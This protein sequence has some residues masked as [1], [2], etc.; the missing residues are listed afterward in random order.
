M[1]SRLTGLL[2]ALALAGFGGSGL[3]AQT[4]TVTG[5]VRD[6]VNLQP[7]AGAQLT[8]EGTGVGGLVNNVGRFLLLNVPA[9]EQTV[10]A[11]LIG[12]G[13]VTQSVTVAAGGTATL[14]FTLREQALS[15]E[16]VI[17]TGT[18]GTARRREIGN[19]ISQVSAADIEV[20]A[21]TDIGD[22]LQGRATG[23][24][25]NDFGG[26]V[27]AGSQIRLRGNS[28]MSAGN[29]P[30][31]YIDGVRMESNPV[32]VDGE[33]GASPSALDM[34]NPNDIER[35]EIVKGPAATTLY[36]TEASGG[37]IQVFTKRGNAGAPAW[38]LD[39][40]QGL[41]QMGHQGGSLNGEDINPTG[42]YLNDCTVRREYDNTAMQFVTIPL[43][44]PGAEV[45]CPSSGSWFQAGHMQ[46]YNLSVRGGGETATY[47]VS[48]RFDD[49]EGVVNPQEAVSYGV[50]ANIS[51]QPFDGMD[52]S[53]NNSF[54]RRN[55]TWIPDGNNASGFLL[56]VMRGS[57]DYTS[58]NDA[59]V[60]ENDIFSTI[61]QYQTSASVGW[62]PNVNWSHRLNVGL[63]Y[64]VMDYLDWK[65]WDYFTAQTGFRRLDSDQDRNVTFDYTGSFSYNP[66]EAVSSR[67]SFGGQLY[68]EQNYNIFGQDDS[69]AGPGEPEVG[70]GTNRNA[71]ET[72][73][74]V[75][76]G[77]FFLQE[78]IGFQDKL[79]LTGG[80]RWDGFSTFGEGFGLAAYPKLSASYLLSDESF[81]PTGV[82]ETLKLRAAWG[83][84]GKAPGVFEAE[85]LWAATSADEQEAAIVLDNFGNPDLGPERSVE[86]ELG[87]DA[88]A[89]DSRV[90]L[91]FTWYDQTTKDALIEVSAAASTGTDNPVW[92]NL[93]EVKNWGTETSL[94]VVPVRSAGVEW[95]VGAQYTTNDSEV[96]DLGPLIDL[97]SSIQLGLPLRIQWDAIL[98]NP[99]EVGVAPVL[100]DGMIGR[101]FP[102]D[103]FAL[104]TRLTLWQSLTID[105]LGEGQFGHVRPVGHAYQNMRRT[106]ATNPV[107]PYCS[108]I[109][110]QWESVPGP[111]SNRIANSGL[112]TDQI[113]Q[114][115]L[116][117][118]DQ[119]M[120]TWDA[121][122][123]KLRSATVSWR[124][125]EDWV[126][127]ARNVLL[128]M[129]GKNLFTS[130]D[131]VGLDP[132][133]GDNG[134]SDNT[135]NDYY[136]FGPPRA[137]ILGVTVSF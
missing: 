89:F 86:L 53:L 121:D 73:T 11:T 46:R 59:L 44:D 37:V 3:A 76:S 13:S 39:V 8:V 60:F 126:P 70:D 85:K 58:G 87:F 83:A 114:C 32:T 124:L 66:L 135:P 4:G 49:E 134:I 50:R 81:W 131:Y 82:V 22:I 28:S 18:A 78:Q 113:A 97:G 111:N 130:T 102:T 10:T 129:Q 55:I 62:S 72:R 79:F 38:T 54:Q 27:G 108:P 128:S 118:S 17:V 117:Y 110:A 107:W 75:R 20:A 123:I 51:F 112:T 14:D 42:F 101:L 120:W 104:T 26:Q 96:V 2:A 52:I 48:G 30:L 94:T 105:V 95:S 91:E 98:Q 136:T 133:A 63:D 122:F 80:V 106:S 103:I 119:G 69:F 24:Q 74:R 132:E 115:H 35:I 90:S 137:L 7:L 33:A 21:V 12:Y 6:A 127:G 71:G 92:S 77:G 43:A 41:R 109:L 67:L 36:G 29:N 57:A 25:I 31:I 100:E 9:G 84:S 34:I 65:Y 93:G 1:G 99:G 16:G 61:N 15:L 116:T 64:T 19:Q 40:D 45:G 23:V 47:F 56:N 125:P 68:E 5:L 88:S